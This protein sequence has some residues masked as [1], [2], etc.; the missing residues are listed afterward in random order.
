MYY[1]L[2]QL[3]F[4]TIPNP[5]EDRRVK[6]QHDGLVKET[7]RNYNAKD[8]GYTKSPLYY[9]DIELLI[10]ES[11]KIDAVRGFDEKMGYWFRAWFSLAYTMIMRGEEIVKMKFKHLCYGHDKDGEPSLRF[12]YV[13]RKSLEAYKKLGNVKGIVTFDIYPNPDEAYIN[14]YKYMKEYYDLLKELP[15]HNVN[16]DAFVF[17]NM[18]PK[19]F[20]IGSQGSTTYIR[21]VLQDYCNAC[22]MDPSKYATHSL[23]HGGA[24]HRY[25]YSSFTLNLDELRYLAGWTSHDTVGTVETYIMKAIDQTQIEDYT[26]MFKRMKHTSNVKQILRW[27]TKTIQ[28]IQEQLSL[29][30]CKIDTNNITITSKV[31]KIAIDVQQLELAPVVPKQ[32]ASSD[33]L[34]DLKVAENVELKSKPNYNAIKDINIPGVPPIERQRGCTTPVQQAIAQYFVGVNSGKPLKHWPYEWYSHTQNYASW[35]QRRNVAELYSKYKVQENGVQHFMDKYSGMT[36]RKARIECQR[37]Y[38]TKYG[39]LKHNK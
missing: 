8:A 22:Q 27:Q 31:Q 35:N 33:P 37:E 24:R 29:I 18:K 9:Y 16:D 5:M 28:Q 7:A 13:D 2:Q 32:C 3:E 17:P 39:K 11:Y 20:M 15:N 26:M 1:N 38:E 4:P 10:K 23:R 19:K 12:T 14:F 36:F 30:S 34:N 6:R 25:I 21:K